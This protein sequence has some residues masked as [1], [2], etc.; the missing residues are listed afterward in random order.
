MSCESAF[1]EHSSE[2]VL[3]I[4]KKKVKYTLYNPTKI[5]YGHKD[6]EII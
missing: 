1:C 2:V 4:K 5:I 3:L 6:L